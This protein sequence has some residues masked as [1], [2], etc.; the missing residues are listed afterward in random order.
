MNPMSGKRLRRLLAGLNGWLSSRQAGVEAFTLILEYDDTQEE[1][2]E[3]SKR[4]ST[5]AD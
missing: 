2:D 3:G 5:P 1:H 4:R